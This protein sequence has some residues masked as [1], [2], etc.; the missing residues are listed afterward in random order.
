MHLWGIGGVCDGLGPGACAAWL[1]TVARFG[2]S[3]VLAVVLAP[4]AYAAWLMTVAHFGASA[5]ATP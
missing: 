4:G 2:A 1:M 3:A 5:V